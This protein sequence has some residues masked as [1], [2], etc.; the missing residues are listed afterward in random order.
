MPKA[1]VLPSIIRK[2]SSLHGWGV[3]ALEPINKNKR[4]IDY[5]GELITNKESEAR[6][7]RY[8]GQGCIWVFRVNRTFSRDANVG[9]NVARF[10]NHSCTPNCWVEVDAKTKT[11]WIRA[12]KA[13]KPGDELTYDYNTEGDKTISCRCRPSCKTRL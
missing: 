11:I 7:E 2:R 3:F 13:I 4:I 8:L 12:A 9:G 1:P 6:E 10:I 5:A